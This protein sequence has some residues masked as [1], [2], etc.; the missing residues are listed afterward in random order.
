[1]AYFRCYTIRWSTRCYTLMQDVT[2]WSALNVARLI[3]L[4]RI[5][6]MIVRR[7]LMHCEELFLCVICCFTPLAWEKAVYII[8]LCLLYVKQLYLTAV[9]IVNH[10]HILYSGFNTSVF[11]HLVAAGLKPTKHS[12]KAWQK[13]DMG[14]QKKIITRRNT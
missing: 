3:Y 4:M 9:F 1:M 6:L 12:R 13:N 11:L 8:N 10:T 5:W 7:T 2:R 14:F